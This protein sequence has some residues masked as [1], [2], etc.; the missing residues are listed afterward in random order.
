MSQTRGLI[1]SYVS[2]ASKAL[3]ALWLLGASACT[4]EILGSA[5]DDGPADGSVLS[6][7]IDTVYWRRLT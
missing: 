6:Q 1:P 5:G 2:T 7:S 4:R 3:L